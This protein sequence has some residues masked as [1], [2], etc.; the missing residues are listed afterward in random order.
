MTSQY[1]DCTGVH[2]K[3]RVPIVKGRGLCSWRNPSLVQCLV[4]CWMMQ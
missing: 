3:S 1:A 4:C 2:D